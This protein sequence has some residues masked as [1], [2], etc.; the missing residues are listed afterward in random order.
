MG[1][2]AAR[3]AACQCQMLSA[4]SQRR[5]SEQSKT[6]LQAAVSA[7]SG[8]CRRSRASWLP[9]R[10]AHQGSQP[11]AQLVSGGRGQHGGPPGAGTA[12]RP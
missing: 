6:D 12:S 8:S 4:Q 10:M 2:S 1:S 11:A 5:A 7:A 9:S 3:C